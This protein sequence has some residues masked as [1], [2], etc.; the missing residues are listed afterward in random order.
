MANFYFK[1][2][3]ILLSISIYATSLLSQGYKKIDLVSVSSNPSQQYLFT[4]IPNIS[5]SDGAGTLQAG[6]AFPTLPAPRF[7]RFYIVGTVAGTTDYIIQFLDWKLT[8]PNLQYAI[9]YNSL[10][11]S[12]AIAAY[13]GATDANKI[14]TIQAAGDAYFRITKTDLL[15]AGVVY[16]PPINVDFSYGIITYLARIRPRTD[17]EASRWSTDL[18]LGLSAGFNFTIKKNH[19]IKLLGGLAVTKVVLDSISTKGVVRATSERP[20]LT[21]SINLFYSYKI[22]SIGLGIGWD[23]VNKDSRETKSWIY[24]RKNFWSIVFGV[25][26]FNKSD[27]ETP[28][29]TN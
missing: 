28:K 23:F 9:R 2:V 26:I 25:S 21:P 1:S 19:S 18:N 8:S 16:D 24:N 12:G 3:F 10:I 20:A 27:T 22:V 6:D 15:D 7:A 11:A 4:G 13:N 5:K 14:A 17:D 29:A